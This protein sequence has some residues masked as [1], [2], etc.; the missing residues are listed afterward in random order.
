M[1]KLSTAINDYLKSVDADVA[2]GMRIAK[3]NNAFVNAVRHVWTDKDI[4]SFIL[5]HTNA[6]YV[7]E[8]TSPRKGSAKDEPYIVYEVCI[9]DPSVRSAVDMKREHLRLA[10]VAEGL[11]LNEFRII[12]A[13]W[14]M[15]KRHPFK[16][17]LDRENI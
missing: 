1:I 15:R 7:R 5:C 17:I 14:N 9:D 11:E 12:P 16:D 4:S 13:R 8:D 2:K 3:N 10:L 6:F